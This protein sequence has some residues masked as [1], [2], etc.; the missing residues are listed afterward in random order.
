MGLNPMFL[1]ETNDGRICL[2]GIRVEV[3]PVARLRHYIS[4]ERTRAIEV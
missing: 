4:L 1:Q 2:R 3:K